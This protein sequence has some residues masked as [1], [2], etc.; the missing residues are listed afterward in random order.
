MQ[1]TYNRDGSISYNL[2]VLETEELEQ[3]GYVY[4]EEN[5]LAAIKVS[6]NNYVVCKALKDYKYLNLQY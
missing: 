6:D 1:K 5:E 2:S 3:T 4:D